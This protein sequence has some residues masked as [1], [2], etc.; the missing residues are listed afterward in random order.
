MVLGDQLSPDL[1]A[2]R[3]ADRARDVVVMAEVMGE[4][5]SVP[6]HP[7]KIALILA[8]M[9]KFAASLRAA[10]WQVSYS[11]LDDPENAQTLSGELLRRAAEFGAGEV[12]ATKPGEWR[13]LREIEDLPVPVRVLE[14]ALADEQ[15]AVNGM[16]LSMDHAALGMIR[17]V[18]SPLHLSETGPRLS[19]PA[20]RLGA[21]SAEV[22]AELGYEAGVVA[23]L[24]EAGVIG[25]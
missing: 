23:G 21:D 4:G 15:T 18:G 17:V 20:P 16:L 24:R 13:V 5:T 9:R 12:L 2:L 19:R 25:G 14:D 6:H 10:G 22:L 11:R 3:A 8:A 1:A 7:Q